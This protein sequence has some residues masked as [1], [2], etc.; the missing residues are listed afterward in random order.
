MVL[1]VIVITRFTHGGWIVV[2]LI[3]IIVFLF[4]QVHKHYVRTAAQLS[5]ED[6]W[7]AAALSRA[8]G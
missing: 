7:P 5:L 1:I 2:V 3:P 6:V 8:T 4:L